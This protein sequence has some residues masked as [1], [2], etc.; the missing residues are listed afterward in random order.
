VL[1]AVAVVSAPSTSAA[2]PSAGETLRRVDVPIDTIQ[3][4]GRSGQS[5]IIVLRVGSSAPVRV[6]LDTG[7]VGLRLWTPPQ[8]QASAGRARQ[9]RD[10][11]GLG[12]AYMTIGGVR[13]TAPATYQVIDTDSTY[14]SR[15]K[16]VGVSGILGVGLRGGPLSNPLSLLPGVLGQRWSIHFATAEPGVRSPS[17]HLVLGAQPPADAQ[18]AF[19]LPA[20]GTSRVGTRL[21]DDHA[22][23]G[24]WTIGR[25]PTACVDTWFDSGFTTM[26]ITGR[27][28]SALPT[29]ASRMLRSGTAVRLSAGTSAFV[30]SRFVAGR[31]GSQDLV[32]VFPRGKAVVNTGN[33]YFFSFVVTYDLT[34]GRIY[35]HPPRATNGAVDV[36]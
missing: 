22:A 11:N 12:A 19:T 29:T 23:N 34:L 16:A 10:D 28:F 14:I 18:M 13:T 4:P 1:A 6:M 27:E 25:E 20:R 33:S 24:C 9:P 35:L 8:G 17:G 30:G 32:R 7:S 5:G 2:T 21:W 15:W 26:R 36:T 31:T 3:T